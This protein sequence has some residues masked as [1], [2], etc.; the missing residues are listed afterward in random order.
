M[1]NKSLI[2]IDS[3]YTAF[4]R[5]FATIRWFSFAFPEE[6]KELKNDTQYDWS[7]NKVFLEKYEKMFL[8][9]IIK[10]IKKKVFD[11]STIIF[12][13]DTPK[14]KLWRTEIDTNY[15]GDRLDM[16][17]KN[18]FKPTFKYTFETMIPNFIKNNENIFGMRIDN[19]EADDL[20][21]S[22][23]MYLKNENLFDMIYIVS[24]DADFHQLGND[25]IMFVNYK[26]KKP[27]KLT[28][29]EAKLSLNTKLIMGDKSDGILSIFPKGARVKKDTLINDN[30]IL[31]EY[32]SKN[33]DAKDQY[34][35]NKKMIDFA[36]IPKKYYNK[37]T[38]EFTKLL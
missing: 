24:G 36:N 19:M 20:I 23:S 33:K 26:H 16:S 4:Y 27:F 3:S 8:D 10:L 29:E 11:S 21:A 13:M 9:S 2:L 30:S 34:E 7:M 37:A 1:P 15:K 32:L 14:E 22:I 18:N 28:E 6:Y 35:F 5:F 12:C 31:E 38:K 17:L 25:S